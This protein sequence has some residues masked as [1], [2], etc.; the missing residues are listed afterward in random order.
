MVYTHTK[1]YISSPERKVVSNPNARSLLSA[2]TSSWSPD[3]IGGGVGSIH[4]TST[5][6][7]LLL[8]DNVRKHAPLKLGLI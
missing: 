7:D 1:F 5:A 3:G 2:R 4:L 6:K 8:W